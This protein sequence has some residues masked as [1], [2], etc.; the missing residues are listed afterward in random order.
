MR[1]HLLP[2]QG[3]G[4]LRTRSRSVVRDIL[5]AAGLTLGILRVGSLT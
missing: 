4:P 5:V 3:V 2:P 1:I